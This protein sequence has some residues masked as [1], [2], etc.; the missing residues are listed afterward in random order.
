MLALNSA[1]DNDSTNANKTDVEKF[2]RKFSSLCQYLKEAEKDNYGF[3][4][5]ICSILHGDG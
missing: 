1:L 4:G 2:I 5:T 3:T